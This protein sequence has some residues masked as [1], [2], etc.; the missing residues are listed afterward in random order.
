MIVN[1]LSGFI[2]PVSSRYLIDTVVGKHHTQHLFQIIILVC[3]GAVL[4]S[5]TAF[6]LTRLLTA[7]ALKIVAQMRQKLQR[8]IGRLPVGYYDANRTGALTARIMADVEGIRHL[9]GAGLLEFTGSIITAVAALAYLVSISPMLT[10][11]VA[12]LVAGFAVCARQMLADVRPLYQERAKIAGEVTGRLVESLNGVRTIKVYHAEEQEA[13]TFARGTERLVECAMKSV[14]ITSLIHLSSSTLLGLVSS[15]VMLIGVSKIL[16]GSLTVGGFF[17]F[18]LLVSL[19]TGPV[20]QLSNIGP[21][22][23]EALA[24]FERVA[25]VLRVPTEDHNCNRTK[26]IGLIEGEVEFDNVGFSYIPGKPVLFGVSFHVERGQVIAIVGPSGAGKSTIISLISTFYTPSNGAIRIDG[27]DLSTIRLDSYRTQVAVV[28]QDTFLFDGTIA[29]NVA[30]SR[31]D[32]S[33]DEITDACR[34]ARVDEFAESLPD[35]YESLVGERGIKLS[36]GQRQR[37]SIARALLAKPRILILDEATS[38]LDSESEA[39]IQ[40]GIDKLIEGRTTFMIAHRLSTIQRADSIF[41]VENGQ[42]IERGNHSSLLALGGRYW[43][44]YTC[45]YGPPPGCGEAGVTHAH[46][47]QKTNEQ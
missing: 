2:L 37:I 44:L 32:A 38:S 25:E 34:I 26:E 16:G 31:P 23:N 5:T 6:G 10:G 15:S 17:M 7:A 43:D 18:T 12:A 45:Q 35:R 30:F 33:H 21:Q 13:I 47:S 22:I 27:T 40:Q 46:Q 14:A 20:F 39:I 11:M 24:G 29:E 19:I 9:I 8:H 36:G 41:V 42:I 1:R 4:Q 3:C 28:L